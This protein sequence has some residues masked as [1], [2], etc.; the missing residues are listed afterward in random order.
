MQ[1]P[2]VHLLSTPTNLFNH[3]YL[4]GAAHSP[5]LRWLLHLCPHLS[6]HRTATPSAIVRFTFPCKA[7]SSLRQE[8]GWSRPP[9]SPQYL[10]HCLSLVGVQLNTC[11]QDCMG[12]PDLRNPFNAVLQAA[13][14]N[15]FKLTQDLKSLHHLTINKSKS[16]RRQHPLAVVDMNSR[17]LSISSFPGAS[18]GKELAWNVGDLGSIPE[19]GRSPK[20]GKGYPL[21]YSCLENSMH[22]GAW[23]A[24]VHGVTKS[25]TWLSD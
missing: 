1:T 12:S 14:I 10:T 23:Q 5:P 21:Q 22:R 11:G 2:S 6:P 24:T 20:E 18:G 4:Q 9:P 15:P 13:S 8:L 17:H 7:L 3:C 25:W 19:L 16:I